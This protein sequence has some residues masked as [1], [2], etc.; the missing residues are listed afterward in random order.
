MACKGDTPSS[1][2]QHELPRAWCFL[3]DHKRTAQTEIL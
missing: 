3:K 2:A 1:E